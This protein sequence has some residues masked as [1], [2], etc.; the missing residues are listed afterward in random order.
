MSQTA[1][2]DIDGEKEGPVVLGRTTKDAS[3]AEE[4][5]ITWQEL[6]K[7]NTPGD[8][9]IGLHGY[10][11]DMTAW[12][13]HHPGGHHVLEL[14]AGREATHLFESYHKLSSRGLIGSQKV[15]KV[16]KLVS[17]EFPL[18]AGESKF[19]TSLRTKVEKYFRENGYKSVRTV[20]PLVL[21]NTLFIIGGMCLMYYLIGFVE[22]FSMLTRMLFA[23]MAGIFHHLSM[24]H[25]WHDMSHYSYGDSPSFWEY[26]PVFGGIFVGHSMD[27]WRH[28][29]VL[30]HHIY[31]NVCGVDPDL[32]I[33]RAA[34]TKPLK[35][36]KRKW[37]AF[38]NNVVVLS[39]KFQPLLY[40]VIVLQ[41]QLDD[42]RSLWG[43]SMEA[44]KFNNKP[45]WRF[46]VPNVIYYI[47]RLVLP[48][49]LGVLSIPATIGLFLITEAVAG[50]LFG[51]FSQITHISLN[52]E[53]PTGTPI[54]KDWAELQVLT[55]RDYAQGSKFWTYISGYLNYQVMHHL[56]PGIAPYHYVPLLPI[57]KETC[58]EFNI[59]YTPCTSFW[60]AVQDHWKHLS[61]FQSMLAERDAKAAAAA[62]AAKAKTN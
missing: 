32:G 11:Y 47:Q 21:L 41:M 61:Q 36:Y 35:P 49:T 26:F 24:V 27:V 40:L 53:W 29:H 59:P 3:S 37:E 5:E 30:G 25:L 4:R 57:L 20:T 44:F 38:G 28:R 62:T 13:A 8:M 45:F 54:P 33:Y 50:S 23:V 43:R 55:A 2:M 42:W 56:F 31:T 7:H 1:V 58:K 17:T 19:Y 48:W 39:T 6:A 10:V 9:W 34:P 51:Y 46:Y 15:P 14:V 60:N 12:A 16:G 52:V 18:Y 22:G